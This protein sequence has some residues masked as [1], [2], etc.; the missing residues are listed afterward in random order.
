MRFFPHCLLLFSSIL[1][2]GRAGAAQAFDGNE[3]A[4][5]A[6]TPDDGAPQG[7]VT[8]FA[9]SADG[10]L[11]MV[12][13][14][15]IA[16]FDGVHFV[17]L[18]ADQFLD[19]GMDRSTQGE[20]QTSQLAGPL[21]L[22]SGPG[23]AVWLALGNGGLW[24]WREGHFHQ[25]FSPDAK[26]HSPIV[27]AFEFPG[28]LVL[29]VT[30][31]GALLR[32]DEHGMTEIGAGRT[33]EPPEGLIAQDLDGAIWLLTRSSHI[34]RIRGAR[35]LEAIP[36]PTTPDARWRALAVDHEG[37]IWLGGVDG[38]FLWDGGKFTHVAAPEDHPAGAVASI[39]PSPTGS[40]W[41]DWSDEARL[42]TGGNWGE[43]LGAWHAN[44]PSYLQTV[45][46]R[47]RLVLAPPGH[48]LQIYDPSGGVAVIGRDQGLSADSA[49]L[50]LDREG[51]IWASAYRRGIVQVRDKRFSSLV[52]TNGAHT[53][54]L[55]TI[56]EAAEGSIWL[57]AEFLAPTAWK[58]GVQTQHFP[59]VRLELAWSH[60][61][62]R[63]HAGDI[64]AVVPERGVYHFANDGFQQTMPWPEGAGYCYALHE[65][66][67]GRWWLG[68][69][70][71]LRCWSEGKWVAWS[72][73]QG[74]RDPATHAIVEDASGALWVGSCHGGIAR[75]DGDHFT[76]FGAPEGLPND[77]VYTL[78]PA[79]DGSL[80]AGTFRGLARFRQGRFTRYTTEQGLPD[81]RVVQLLEDGCGY[82]WIGTRSGLIR[83]PLSS[84]DAVDRGAAG[85]LDSLN[86]SASDGLPTRTFQDRTSPGCLQTRDGALWFLTAAGAISCDPR[87]I[88][89]NEVRP[90]AA[91]EE[92]S[93]DGRP[94]LERAPLEKTAS[95]LEEV[96][97]QAP[98]TLTL[99]PGPH[100]L[101]IK[102]TA[103]SM[104]DAEKVKFEYRLAGFDRSWIASDLHRVA[105]Y[106]MIPP[107]AYEFQVRAANADGRW[108]AN[109]ATLPIIAKPHLWQ[110]KWF[111]FAA[112]ATIAALAGGVVAAWL[113]VRHRRRLERLELGFALQKERARIARDMHDELGASLTQISITTELAKFE[114]AEASRH[115][116]DIAAIT[117][118]AVTSL[119][120]IVWAVNPRND[121]LPNFL[122]YLGQHAVDYLHSAGIACEIDFPAALPARP[123]PAE[124]RHHIFLIAKE[125]LTNVV[126]HAAAR[127]V[128]I[129]A[130]FGDSVVR[131]TIADDGA[132]FAYGAG[133]NGS[134]G[135]QN[136]RDRMAE[137]GG[138]CEIASAP[139]QGT[140]I[141]FSVPLTARVFLESP[142]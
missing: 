21:R 8:S 32:K 34:L 61:L 18:E 101:A 10:Y 22:L 54:S 45:D 24:R 134:D 102:F 107:G 97:L 121:T 70:D 59:P 141:T 13:N 114:P 91:F 52:L 66:R 73:A 58:S 16:R 123:F 63:D 60:V 113:R 130:A 49:A 93:V 127:S 5:R 131:L 25:I 15:A 47:G 46:A 103:P 104:S 72:Q 30:A 68:S 82:L 48:G 44:L 139:G 105:R 69:Y 106:G 122:E 99:L 90:Q 119:D 2:F 35:E 71:G 51:N 98:H 124:A 41:I 129:S 14:D 94:V 65:D 76:A 125:A 86:F 62:A 40:L 79:A 84:F 87:R 11:W 17:T 117:R 53:P 64:Y 39:I 33:L 116:R 78:F 20:R 142:L 7:Y 96:A 88:Q 77:S 50:F 108:S 1:A 92:I 83:V 95:S 80:W 115:I 74:L 28:N 136:I 109:L 81:D 3:F 12:A 55:W 135:L 23:G 36:S 89:P 111:P 126:K 19:V 43:S 140:R 29:G 38:L 112:G 37:H 120:E 56:C 31:E 132:G 57:G 85:A 6:W 27:K 118:E 128:Q 138:S 67:Q 75:L 26:A 9:Q 42:Y 100:V 137:L 4:V 110:T 133:K